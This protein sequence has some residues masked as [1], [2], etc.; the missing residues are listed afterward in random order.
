MEKLD[1][2]QSITN[3]LSKYRKELSGRGPIDVN[4]KI[5]GHT[6]YVKMNLAF[7][8]MEKSMYRFIME[9]NGLD[10]FNREHLTE[11]KKLIDQTL[12]GKGLNSYT[13]KIILNPDLDKGFL[14][15]IIVLNNNIEKQ[16]IK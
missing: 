1:I 14:Y 6:I 9:N 16:L 3:I 13:E 2:E 7:S 10:K 11:G 12:E 15:I 8:R 5:L 4:A